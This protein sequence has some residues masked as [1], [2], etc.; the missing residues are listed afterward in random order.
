MKLYK[1]PH[2]RLIVEILDLFKKRNYT[3]VSLGEV[4]I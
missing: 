2:Y 1:L 3:K 4:D